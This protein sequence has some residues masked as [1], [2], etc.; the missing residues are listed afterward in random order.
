[1]PSKFTKPIVRELPLQAF[2]RGWREIEVTMQD[3]VLIFRLKGLKTRYSVS[4]K[5][6]LAD[7]FK[8]IPMNI[9]ETL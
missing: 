2:D 3:N 1:M 4:M 9:R 5:N 7:A 6:I 8:G